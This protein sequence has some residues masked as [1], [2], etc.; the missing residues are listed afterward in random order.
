MLVVQP[1]N[2]EG[3]EPSSTTATSWPQASGVLPSLGPMCAA[4]SC[5]IFP[6]LQAPAF[7]SSSASAAR[8]LSPQCCVC[9]SA[10]CD[11]PLY[12]ICDYSVS[13]DRCKDLGCCFY[14]GVCYEKAVPSECGAASS[15]S[16]H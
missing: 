8:G 12:D 5:V 10:V 15:P 14:K 2:A 1:L 7:G 11:I 4:L 3:W 16:P 13:R 9:A 6:I